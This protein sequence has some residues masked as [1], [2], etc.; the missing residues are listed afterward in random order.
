MWLNHFPTGVHGSSVLNVTVLTTIFNI[1]WENRRIPS[2]WKH[3]TIT[4]LPKKDSSSLDPSDWRPISLLTSMYKIYMRLV[5]SRVLPWIVATERLSQRQKG[6]LPRNGLQEHVFCLKASIDNFKHTSAKFYTAF[7][8]IRDA[9]G[10]VDHKVM[11][12]AMMRAGYPSHIVDITKDIYTHSTFQVQT[13]GAPTP[14]ITRS[15]GIVQGCPWSAIAFIQALDP[16]IRWME[17]PYPPSTQPTPCQ[18]YMDDVCMSAEEEVDIVEMMHKT[19]EFMNYTGM[20]VKHAKCALVH[21][22]RTGNNWSKKDSTQKTKL[23]LQGGEI[24]KLGRSQDYRYLGFRI[25][26]DNTATSKQVEEVKDSFRNTIEKIDNSPLPISNKVEAINTMATAK[27]N[28]YFE[29]LHFSEKALKELEDTITDL[30]RDTMK[31]NN[32]ATRA[33]IFAPRREGGLGV[34]KPSTIY[35]AKRVSFLLSCLNSD[36][37]QVRTVARKT[38]SLHMNKRK[39]PVAG[40]EEL[41]FGGFKTNPSGRIS[42]GSKVNWPR[43]AFVELNELCVRLNV[44]LEHDRDTDLY[45]VAVPLAD[46]DAIALR[47]TDAKALYSALKRNEIEKSLQHWRGLEQQGRLLREAVPVADMASSNGHLKNSALT[48]HLTRFIVKGRL[49]LLETSAV[50]NTYYPDTYRRECTLCRYP[51]D[52]NSHA[53]NGCRKLRGLYTERHDRCVEVIFC[54]LSKK[55]LTEYCEVFQNQPVTS[56]GQDMGTSKPDI[57]ILDHNQSVAFIVEVSIPFDAFLET[58]YQHKFQKYLPLHAKLCEAGFTTKIVVLVIGSLGHVHRH[59]VPGLSMLGLSRQS[60]KALA[61][62]LSI[63]AMIGSRRV[64]ARRGHMMSRA[65][66]ERE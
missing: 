20:E 29:N 27:L 6:S 55:V 21:A 3:A 64:W 52:T 28:F 17:Q 63:S 40:E 37:P 26:L 54:E 56:Q 8:D 30:I 45:W 22:Q 11:L 49:Q 9:Y 16:W 46:D 25:D 42:K 24:P 34:I 38:F 31:L 50:N 58:C 48:D 59:V 57:C 18:A 19:E 1:C 14:K 10:S 41:S 13:K 32:S 53:L 61:R 66:A 7:V 62:Y 39:V 5:Q 44:H 51:T 33:L 65:V 43:S 4:L 12:E 23:K 15:K 36:D 60:S 47:F 2:D 35:H